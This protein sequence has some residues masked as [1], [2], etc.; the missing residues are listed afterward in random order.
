MNNLNLSDL[1]INFENEIEKK[2]GI[3]RQ[4][5]NDLPLWFG[6]PDS[7]EAYC[8]GARNKP[9]I[10][11]I[12]KNQYIGFASLK[13]NNKYTI[14]IY[15]MAILQKYHRMGIGKKLIDKI[16]KYAKGNHYQYIEVKTLDESRESEEYK[17][18]RLFYVKEGFVPIDVLINEWGPGYPCLIMIKMVN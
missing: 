14:E 6:I 2:E 1:E 3:C 17:K 16:V 9:F 13:S 8:K 18:T 15:V 7:N 12:L 4:I 5:L 10:S 11:V